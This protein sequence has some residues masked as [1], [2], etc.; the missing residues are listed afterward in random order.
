MVQLEARKENGNVVISE[1]S[2][3]YLLACLENQRFVGEAPP[4]G[5]A[6]SP[7]TDYKQIQ[8]DNQ[9]AIDD[10]HRQCRTLLHS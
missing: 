3:E 9:N 4:C 2:F 5:D 10:F 8:K 6:M 7:D 1:G